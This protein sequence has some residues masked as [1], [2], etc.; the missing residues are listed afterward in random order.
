[1]KTINNDVLFKIMLQSIIQH[2]GVMLDSKSCAKVLS[3]STRTLDERRKKSK[4]CP[5]YIG[6]GKGIMFPAQSIIEYQLTKSKECIKTI[7]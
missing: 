7:N 3:I 1:M 2:Y 5:E 4:N 6:E